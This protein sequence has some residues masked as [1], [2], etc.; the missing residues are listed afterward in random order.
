MITEVIMPKLG[1]TME[2]GYLLKWF[3]KEGEKVNKGEPLFEVMS[4]KTNFEV[5]A[6]KDGYLRKILIEPG[7]EPIPVTNV[8]GYL[9]DSLEE[10]LP[11][12]KIEIKEEETFPKER[13]FISPLARRL[14]EEKGIDISNIKGS[15][16]GG[17]IEKKD[18]L[19]IGKG[20][21]EYEVKPLSPIKQVV[22]SRLSRSKREIPHYYLQ[23]RIDM[24][25]VERRK[26][27]LAASEKKV[28]FT[29]L[30]IEAIS[31]ALSE[32]PLL[33]SHFK[34]GKVFLFK[35]INLG[36][37]VALPEG[38]VVP[39]IK[40]IG[41]KTLLQIS[42]ERR[43]LVERGRSGKLSSKETDGATFT[44]SNLGTA[45]VDNFFPIIDL[46]QVGILG[47]GRIREEAVACNGKVSCRLAM[48]V[49]L[50][51]DHRVIDGAYGASFLNKLK[52]VLEKK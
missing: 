21:L 9:S 8:I 30:I 12:E 25:E 15:G 44:L 38:L 17:R 26:D 27:K 48:G 45:G 52:E 1:E 16:P 32:F 5:E 6:V 39:V 28:T 18:I 35:K 51:L 40:D 36:L 31:Q 2:E 24:E 14:V 13:I 10:E 23:A 20:E 34:E 43:D 19:E 41:N 37:A 50:S 22:A 42:E 11:K 33:N 46:S 29:D 3:K 4:D 47:C 7:E 49:V